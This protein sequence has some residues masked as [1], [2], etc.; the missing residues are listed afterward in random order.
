MTH[1]CAGRRV[2]MRFERREIRERHGSNFI[3]ARIDQCQ[4]RRRGDPGASKQF[5]QCDGDRMHT[6]TASAR[7]V[8]RLAPPLQA[9]SRPS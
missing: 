2:D 1:Q 4:Q 6:P 7:F 5:R 3:G 9:G 8:H